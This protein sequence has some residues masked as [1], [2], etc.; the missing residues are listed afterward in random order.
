MR[1]HEV[2]ALPG[3]GGQHAG[4]VTSPGGDGRGATHVAKRSPAAIGRP[5]CRTADL[6][7]RARDNRVVHGY[8]HTG[9]PQGWRAAPSMWRPGRTV[10]RRDPPIRGTNVPARVARPVAR[11][12]QQPALALRGEALPP[13]PSTPARWWARTPR[14]HP[15]PVPWPAGRAP[16][17]RA[18][19]P[20]RASRSA[21]WRWPPSS[22]PPPGHAS[23]QHKWRGAP[24]CQEHRLGRP[25]LH[26]LSEREPAVALPATLG[27]A[28]MVHGPCH[29]GEGC[30]RTA[31]VWGRG[32]IAPHG[33]LGASRV[34]SCRLGDRC[35]QVKRPSRHWVGGG[36]ALAREVIGLGRGAQRPLRGAGGRHAGGV[37]SPRGRMTVGVQSG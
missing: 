3:P 11:L 9:R 27:D 35:S 10:A 23:R 24:G 5:V 18:A 7:C 1:R 14:P 16:A 37:T 19:G 13:W 12:A 17:R 33:A 29:H 26:Q 6:H 28:R 34:A 22:P 36:R 25:S 8:I 2:A 30:P 21:G 15:H 32:V 20:R 31:G 4:R